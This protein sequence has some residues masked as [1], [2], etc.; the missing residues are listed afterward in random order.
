MKSIKETSSEIKLIYALIVI[1]FLMNVTMCWRIRSFQ[2]N[3]NEKAIAT[4]ID[5][6]AESI[7]NSV[8]KYV[9]K[10]Q[11]EAQKQQQSKAGENIKKFD[12]EL[13]DTKT[14]GII[15][16]KGTIEIV[17]FFDYN[18]GYCKMSAKNIEELLKERTD[19]KVILRAI[20]ILGDASTYATNVGNAIIL[21][22]PTKYPTFYKEIMSGSARNKEG[23]AKAVEACGIKMSKVE[24]F[25]E[26]NQDKVKALIDANVGLARQI[27]ING[28]PAF[29]VN[30][31]LIPGAID[32]ATLKSKLTK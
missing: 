31:E 16:P 19:V 5:N 23:V 28:T 18:C 30:G 3:G 11:E 10:Q 12:K 7:L 13:H 26:K 20:P 4:W 6:N 25:L 9:T 32:V 21:M 27:G 8:N 2:K 1:L 22:E 17:E 24:K 14:A 15:N 29:I